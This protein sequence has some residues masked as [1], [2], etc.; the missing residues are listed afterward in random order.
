[1]LAAGDIAEGPLL[2]RG[3]LEAWLL[4]GQ[5][6]G[7]IAANTGEQPDAVN[8]FEKL[9]F[10]ARDRLDARDLL[11]KFAVGRVEPGDPPEQQVVAFMKRNAFLAVS[12]L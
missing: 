9:H 12:M 1:M 11:H 10:A 6:D 2:R 7:E 4:T 3:V 5:S 8:W